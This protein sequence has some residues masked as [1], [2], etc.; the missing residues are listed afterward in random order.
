MAKASCDRECSCA[1]LAGV[2]L[3]YRQTDLDTGQ[4]S[5]SFAENL[6][7]KAAGKSGQVT[8]LIGKCQQP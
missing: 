6:Y 5:T 4:I 2:K 1:G 3:V 8:S 7:L